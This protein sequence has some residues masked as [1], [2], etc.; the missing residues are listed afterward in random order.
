MAA[1]AV[2]IGTPYLFFPFQLTCFKVERAFKMYH[3]GERKN[4]GQFSHEK[5]GNM[6][7]DYMVSTSDLSE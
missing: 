1:A 4:V 5:V 3:S 7:D 2:S 6:I